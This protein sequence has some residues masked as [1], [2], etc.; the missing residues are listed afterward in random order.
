MKM[1]TFLTL[2]NFKKSTVKKQKKIKM[3]MLK[4]FGKLYSNMKKLLINSKKLM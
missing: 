1:V 4:M 3:N 2:K